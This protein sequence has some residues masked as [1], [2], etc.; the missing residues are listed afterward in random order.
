MDSFNIKDFPEPCLQLSNSGY[1]VNENSATVEF[2][3]HSILKKKWEDCV[4]DYFSEELSFGQCATLKN[5]K[6]VK[7]F[8]IGHY[9][10]LVDITEIFND[11]NAILQSQHLKQMHRMINNV[12]HQIRTPVMTAK[13]TLDSLHN[14][15]NSLGS[16]AKSLK[17]NDALDEI[18]HKISCFLDFSSNSYEFVRKF[19]L[20]D[21]FDKVKRSFTIDSER[22]VIWNFSQTSLVGHMELLS[23]AL[24]N[25]INNAMEA[26]KNCVYVESKIDAQ[27]IVIWVID[28][29]EGLSEQ[30]FQACLKP[31]CSK[32]KKSSG[33]GLSIAK[34]IIEAHKGVLLHQVKTPEKNHGV[35]LFI[36]LEGQ[37]KQQELMHD[38]SLVD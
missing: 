25:L 29:G 28:E 13:L 10:F 34:S 20:S 32:N 27:G 35:G 16:V 19:N 14:Q 24:M 31:Y 15:L 36:P 3:E 26:T 4:G 9:L 37:F 1:V 21:L 6:K 23:E 2:F 8:S 30:E 22:K 17:I 18:N 33:L 11:W 38:L 5:G 12:L 7:L